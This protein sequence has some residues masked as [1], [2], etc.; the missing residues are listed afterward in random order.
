ML[1][2]HEKK[3]KIAQKS[4]YQGNDELIIQCPLIR[5]VITTNF[6]RE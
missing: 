2:T 3:T 6:E 5:I 1:E 4:S